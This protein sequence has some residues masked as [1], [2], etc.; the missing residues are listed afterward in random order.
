MTSR[1]PDARTRSISGNAGG[2]IRRIS[3]HLLNGSLAHLLPHNLAIR[4][5]TEQYVSAALVEHG[6]HGSGGLSARSCRF[7]ELQGLGFACRRQC[8]YLFRRHCRAPSS[9]EHP[10]PTM[11]ARSTVSWE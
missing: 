9:S 8:R 10:G 5:D 11:R 6:T 1:F 7:L 3:A 2:S 4:R